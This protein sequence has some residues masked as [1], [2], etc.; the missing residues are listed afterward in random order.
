M[1]WGEY[2]HHLDSK[3]RLIIP[4]QYRKRLAS[5]A[6]LTR[7]ID[8]NLVIYPR[9]TW[10]TVV[11]QISEMPITQPTGRAL[12]RLLF[13]GA[14]ELSTDKQGRALIPPYLREYASINGEVMVIGME[15]FIELWQPESWYE[16]IEDLS[17]E[18]A[19]ADVSLKL[20][21]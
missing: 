15:T 14:V 12:R 13:S 2:R 17:R 6:I 3:G 16:T 7:G 4:A 1:F 5:D 18:L 9:D 10:Q 21:L 20:R 11:E 8:H 19:L